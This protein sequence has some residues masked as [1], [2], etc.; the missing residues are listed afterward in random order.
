MGFISDDK[1]DYLRE[2]QPKDFKDLLWLPVVFVL[3]LYGQF[4]I[5]PANEYLAGSLHFIIGGAAFI[6]SNNGLSILF[7]LSWIMSP[8]GK[9]PLDIVTPF[10][11]RVLG[12]V[13]IVIG[14][15]IFLF[16]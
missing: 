11:T 13:L 8:F 10:R 6:M 14:I 2:L 16:H 3:Y 4:K 7:N 12:A 1:D 9:R 5:T 15:L